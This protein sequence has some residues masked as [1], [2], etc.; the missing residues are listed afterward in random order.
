LG[1]EVLVL[2]HPDQKS[3]GP[4]A[5]GPNALVCNDTKINSTENLIYSIYMSYLNIRHI[6]LPHYF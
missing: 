6:K 1:P 5:S 4:D 3:L 2:T